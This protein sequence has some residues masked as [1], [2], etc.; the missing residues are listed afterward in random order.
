MCLKKK[1]YIT[2][3]RIKPTTDS[4][5]SVLAKGT[6]KKRMIISNEAMITPAGI[7]IFPEASGLFFLTGWARSAF[8]STRSLI[9]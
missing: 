3:R 7:L 6:K 2:L 1:E 5:N 9:T 4:K 8:I